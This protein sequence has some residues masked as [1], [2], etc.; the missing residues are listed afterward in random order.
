MKRLLTIVSL[1]IALSVNAQVFDGVS[2]SGD[3]PTAIAKL[4]AKG[5]VFKKYL[6]N[7]AILNGK[8]GFQKSELFIYVTPKSKVVYKFVIYLEEQT[9][10]NSLKSDYDKY[11]EIFKQKYGEPDNQ[12][13]FFSSPYKE[14][15]GYELTAV[16]LEKCTFSAY[17]LSRNNSSISI[18]ISKWNQ[19]QLIYE[20]DSNTDLKEKELGMIEKNIF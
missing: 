16:T 11:F 8:V 15:D 12:Y 1:F 10:W 6:E 20:N 4:K 17:W 9:T 19:V 2:V 18:N 13:S 3:L 14:G 5:Y 7:G